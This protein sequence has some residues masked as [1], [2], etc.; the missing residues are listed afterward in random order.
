M[1]RGCKP[2]GGWGAETD[3]SL[4]L[5][6]LT[7][8]ESSKP[9][10]QLLRKDSGDCPCRSCRWTGSEK[11][12]MELL[13]KLSSL[14]LQELCCCSL[15]TSLSDPVI[16]LIPDKTNPEIQPT[17]PIPNWEADGEWGGAGSGEGPDTYPFL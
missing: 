16:T 4:E 7:Y 6:S 8:L 1:A 11:K 10:K 17:T 5:A 9:M 2:Q 14:H 12:K 13:W 15:L 3:G